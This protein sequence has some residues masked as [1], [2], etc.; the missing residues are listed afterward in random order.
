MRAR[1]GLVVL[2]LPGFRVLN[3][4]VAGRRLAL[5][6]VVYQLG[7]VVLVA[8]AF[9]IQGGAAAA[10]AVL[11]GLAG[12]VGNLLAARVALGGGVMPARAAFSRLLLGAL[13]KWSA[14]VTILALALAVWRMAPLPMLAGFAIGVFAHLLILNFCTRVERER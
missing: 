5:R 8:L 2:Q 13:L 10:A 4:V 3:S 9:L 1:T 14:V 11:G 12:V 7:V 6:A